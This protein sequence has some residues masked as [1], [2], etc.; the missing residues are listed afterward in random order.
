MGLKEMVKKAG[1]WYWT[2]TPKIKMVLVAGAVVFVGLVTPNTGQEP[3]RAAATEVATTPTPTWTPPPAPAPKKDTPAERRARAK[4]E[5]ARLEAEAKLAKQRA[6]KLK[7][8]R[9]VVRREARREAQREA[10]RRE[11]RRVAR[12]ITPENVVDLMVLTEGQDLITNFCSAYF[13]VGDY[14]AALRAF[15]VGYTENNP[16]AIFD[17]ILSRC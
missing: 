6:A 9:E 10:A 12:L 17:E 16:E 3:T 2:R 7:E 13:L 5:V 4:Q 14:D 11:A 1:K 15:K 8:Q